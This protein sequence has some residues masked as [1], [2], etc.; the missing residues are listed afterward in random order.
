MNHALINCTK[1]CAYA[2]GLHI[3]K[4][5]MQEGYF[6]TWTQWVHYDVFINFS[7]KNLKVE[8]V[9][10]I[11]IKNTSNHD[12]NNEQNEFPFFENLNWEQITQ[13][14]FCENGCSLES[15]SPTK[16]A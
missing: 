12:K 14:A 4:K 15:R 11:G 9:V 2:T 1:I 8:Q 16:R 3:L 10:Y 7:L 5:M 6:T 13:H